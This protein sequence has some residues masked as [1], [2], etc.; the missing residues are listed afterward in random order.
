MIEFAPLTLPN[1]QVAKYFAIAA[2]VVAGIIILGG[3]GFLIFLFGFLLPSI[4]P[5]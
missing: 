4:D 1:P 3:T 2:F 5:S